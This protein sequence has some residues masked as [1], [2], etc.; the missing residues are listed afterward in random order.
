M[1]CIKGRSDTKVSGS[2]VKLCSDR[3]EGEYLTVSVRFNDRAAFCPYFL[4]F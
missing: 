2:Q 4:S 1:I 3:V